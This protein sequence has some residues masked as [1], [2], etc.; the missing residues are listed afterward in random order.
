MTS[1]CSITG[2]AAYYTKSISNKKNK[3]KIGDNKTYTVL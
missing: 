3:I 1:I 2:E